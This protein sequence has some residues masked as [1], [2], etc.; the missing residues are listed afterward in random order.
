MRKINKANTV[1]ITGLYSKMGS[2]ENQ[3]NSL[4][5]NLNSQIESVVNN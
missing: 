3:F 2:I 5:S 1:Q 4:L